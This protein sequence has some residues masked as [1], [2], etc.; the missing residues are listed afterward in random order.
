MDL[1]EIRQKSLSVAASLG[2]E[3]NP[4]L[5]LLE[6]VVSVRSIEEVIDRSLALFATVAGSYGF[7]KK[8]ALAWLEKEGAVCSLADSEKAFLIEEIGEVGSVQSQV[9]A[10]QAFAWSLGIVKKMEFDQVCDNNLIKLFP[11]IKNDGSSDG[12][13]SKSR[14]RDIEDIISACDLA[15]CLHWAVTQAGLENKTL[16]NDVAPHVIIERR[17]ALEWLLGKEDWDDISL[18]T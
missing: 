5:P 13:K 2:Y 7:D 8:R 18:D 12:F 9:E 14:L 6:G 10:L 16:P 17:R 1:K 4:D 15:Y 3:T 11:D